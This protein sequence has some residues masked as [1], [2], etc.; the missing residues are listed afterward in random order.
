LLA[1]LFAL[2][3]SAA[4]LDA[5]QE[6]TSETHKLDPPAVSSDRSIKYDYDIVYVRVPRRGD[7]F[8]SRFADVFNPT[9][10]DPGAD[11]MLLHPDGSEEEL[12][13]GGPGAVADPYVSFDGEWV[14]FAK[15]HN[16]KRIAPAS[17]LPVGGSDIYKVHVKTRKVV[18]LTNQEFTP[19]S[20]V[21]RPPS[22]VFNL[23]PCPL[24]GGRVMFT[25]SRNGF[26]PPK[27]YTKPTLQLFVMDDDGKNV[28]M[29]GHLNVSSSLHPTVLR[30]GRVM[31]S[32]HES[33]GLRDRRIWSIWTIHPDGTSWN[34]LVSVFLEGQAFHFMS[35]LSDGSVI[36]EEYYNLNNNGFGTFYKLPEQPAEGYPAF[37]PAFSRDP[38]NLPYRGLPFFR[39]PFTPYGM[40][41]LTP[42]A[43]PFDGP[44]LLSDPH[45][46]TSPRLGKLTHPSGAP[47]NHL[48]CVW[49]P[50]PANH[51]NGLK[52]PS[53]DA[54]IY[55]I[56]KAKPVRYPAE[57]FKIKNDPRYNEQ[58]PRA[59]V[60]YR[61]V[62]G[63]DEPRRIPP[64]AN[65]GQSSPHL[66][67]GTPFGLVGTSSLYKR[68]S[69]P[70]GSV[71]KGKVTAVF[72]GQDKT[73]YGGLDRLA[74]PTV[75]WFVQGSDAGRY[76]NEDIHAVRFVVMEPTSDRGGQT[77]GRR[78]WSHANER[79]RI[80]G[81]LPVRKFTGA[82]QETDP[83]GNPDTSFLA[84]L[85]ADVPWTFQTLDKDGMVL[86]MAQTWHQLRPG[87]I[88]NNCGGCHAHSQKP[89]LFAQTAA[90]RSDYEVFDLAR[91]TPLLTAKARDESGKK[92]DAK[93]QTG[94]RYA[95]GIKTVEFYRDVKPI[96]ERSCT[97]CHT[98][99]WAEVAGN[100]V[101]D[102]EALVKGPPGIAGKLPGPPGKIPGTY[103]RL[104][105]D[106]KARFGYKPLTGAWRT[107]QV[108]R[109]VRMFQSRRSLLMWKVLGRRTD[110]WTNDDFPSEKVPGDPKSLQLRGK[111]L[112][113]TPAN[114]QRA[115]LDFTGSAM[116]PPEA[117]AGTYPG[118]DG[119]KV[120]VQPLTDEDRR[121]LARWI[122]LGCPID[123]DYDPA[124]PDEH[125][126]GWL[127]DEN[128][129]TL[130]LT[131]PRRGANPRLTGILV[132]MHDY[133][134]GL[135]MSGFE[136]RA[137]FRVNG[138]A[139]GTDLAHRFRRKPD[140]VWELKLTRPITHLHRG[141]L[142]VAVRDREG[143][144]TRIERTFSVK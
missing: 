137:D 80:L 46:K 122:D 35:Q 98:K 121:T 29:I 132:G 64:L 89:T 105:A 130:T 128:R 94:L 74:G 24:P 60:P 19:N 11:L 41:W 79:M 62:Y 37:G 59:L 2:L 44:A 85:P 97:A 4:L 61:R 112:P 144:V 54:G 1:G 140:G 113:L 123:L 21:P 73:G 124:R 14:Y 70:G 27:G 7:N 110:G 92:W 42:F 108:S 66:P 71:P 127:R 115:D 52:K 34:P 129:P 131:Y 99:K 102:D 116:P 32:T 136:V 10:M 83:D 109:Y 111:P 139:P 17:G 114:R 55:L 118:P 38:R 142:T 63:V 104:A 95:K 9:R 133:Y 75:N 69:F 47:D 68:E 86:N 57:M 125:G 138:A 90:A 87:E 126:F 51:N 88:R 22:G 45:D 65:D 48:L 26:T 28:E 13:P 31:F 101:L 33:Q 103:M 30:D 50:G 100:L 67:E 91:H 93:D 107:P 18:Q 58:W 81:E 76:S 72:A 20:G 96:L 135:D 56:K 49:S 3:G 78:F 40:Q 143:N 36:V 43:S 106:P 23:G 15:F 134:T 12:V 8:N 77:A 53:Y 119:E 16:Q 6:Q 117:V 5:G 82:K 39:I 141:K 84:R 25:S 120:K